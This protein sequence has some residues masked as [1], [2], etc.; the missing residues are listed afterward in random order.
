VKPVR[1][2]VTSAPKNGHLFPLV[3]LSRALRAA[4]HDVLA[5]VP[6]VLVGPASNAGL[7][8][9]SI[10]GA[11]RQEPAAQP[12]TSRNGTDAAL[13]E[14]VLKFY[15]P[16]AEATVDR[17]IEV[18]RAWRA[19]LVMHSGW[20]YAGPIAAAVCGIPS[21]F[22][23]GGLLPVDDIDQAAHIALAPVRRRLRA[24]PWASTAPF[25]IDVCP[26]GFARAPMPG[27][28]PMSYLPYN[29]SAVLAPWLLERPERPRIC[30]TLGNI[31]VMGE[32]DYVVATVLKAFND[33]D[34]E[35]IVAAADRLS[36]TVD[37]YPNAR[38]ERQL[39]LHQLLPTCQLSIHHGGAGSVM[40]SIV[41]GLPQLV[42]PQTCVQYQHA[43]QVAAAEAG[44]CLMPE[45]LDPDTIRDT[46][47]RLLTDPAPAEAVRA[48]RE[49]LANRPSPAAVA[50]R[51]EPALAEPH[52]IL[53]LRPALAG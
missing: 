44:A 12:L 9:I 11:L 17:L 38:L 8:A 13:V 40:T 15:V 29:G 2:L 50:S 20:E 23:S 46:A 5:A 30:V 43:Q 33:F 25:W 14:H 27:G 37:Q 19:D 4:G 31:P 3:P 22:H 32:H 18:A 21:L 53:E 42:L 34:A 48:L 16:F 47:L 26:P 36:V 7:P 39:P 1:V 45:Q 35:V 49:E 41:A 51:L 6:E 10:G 28:L 52:R 24:R